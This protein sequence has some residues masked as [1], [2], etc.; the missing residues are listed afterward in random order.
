MF[1]VNTQVAGTASARQSHLL[2][3]QKY[4]TS[5]LTASLTAAGASSPDAMCPSRHMDQPPDAISGGSSSATEA[6]AAQQ[7]TLPETAAG[8][9]LEGLGSGNNA[10]TAGGLVTSLQLPR[11]LL[12]WASWLPPDSVMTAMSTAAAQQHSSSTDPAVV[13]SQK[14][15][16]TGSAGQSSSSLV[17][18]SSAV[19]VPELLLAHLQVLAEQLAQSGHLLAALPVLHLARLVALVVLESQVRRLYETQVCPTGLLVIHSSG[20]QGAMYWKTIAVYPVRRQ[21]HGSLHFVFRVN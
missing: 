7:Y 12:G 11:Q 17:L 4:A 14:A 2:T 15:S 20:V 18:C 21:D 6:A 5:M 8:A 16:G 13:G 1:T 10:P 19:L 3:A 9:A